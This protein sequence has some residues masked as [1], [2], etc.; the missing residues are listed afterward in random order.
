MRVLAWV[1]HD[2]QNVHTRT[3]EGHAGL[4]AWW[5]SLPGIVGVMVLFGDGTR[6]SMEASE[7]YGVLPTGRERRRFW[8]GELLADAPKDAHLIRGQLV[9]DEIYAIASDEMGRA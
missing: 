2:G 7:W 4:M 9:P 8:N 6:H 1:S 5:R 3:H